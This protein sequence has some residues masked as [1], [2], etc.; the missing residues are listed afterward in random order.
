LRRTFPGS[1]G[2]GLDA[3]GGFAFERRFGVFDLR[4]MLRQHARHLAGNQAMGEQAFVQFAC[5][6]GEADDGHLSGAG[7]GQRRH[8]LPCLP[9]PLWV[10]DSYGRARSPMRLPRVVSRPTAEA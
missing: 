9:L 8:R 10:C 6:A 4:Q 2:G 1:A 7:A 3:V 5:A